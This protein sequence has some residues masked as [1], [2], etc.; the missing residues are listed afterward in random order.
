MSQ[1][2][3][4]VEDAVRQLFPMRELCARYGISRRVGDKWLA[5]Y[6]EHGLAGLADQ[7]RRP[8]ASPTRL[9]GELAALLIE[10]RQRHPTW[11][12]RKLLAYLSGRFTT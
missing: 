2:R 11:G 1:R 5:R 6:R 12:A 10:A 8:H 4:F 9:E 3:E 7:S